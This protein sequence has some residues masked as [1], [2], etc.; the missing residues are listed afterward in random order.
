MAITRIHPAQVVVVLQKQI[1]K[2]LP[3][4]ARVIGRPANGYQ[5]DSIKVRPEVVEVAGPEEVIKELENLFTKSVDIGGRRDSLVQEVTLDFRSLQIN[6]SRHQAIEV[7]VKIKKN[8][9]PSRKSFFD[10]WRG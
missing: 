5:V 10:F 8:G 7:E 4:K 3:V 9:A 2:T 6:L 1:K